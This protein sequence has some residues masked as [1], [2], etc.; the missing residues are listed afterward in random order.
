MM[1]NMVQSYSVRCGTE[2][3]HRDRGLYRPTRRCAS[4][5]QRLELKRARNGIKKDQIGLLPFAA[6]QLQPQGKQMC[7]AVP[8]T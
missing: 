6:V 1:I 8:V 2:R 3:K 7:C 4:R 5:W